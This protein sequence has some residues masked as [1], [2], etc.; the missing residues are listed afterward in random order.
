MPGRAA[1]TAELRAIARIGDAD[2]SD[3][4]INVLNVAQ[5]G[6]RDIPLGQVSAAAGRASI[7]FCAAAIDAAMAGRSRCG[8]GGAAERDLDRAGRHRVRRPSVVRGAADRHRRERGL[9]DAVL[10]RHPDRALHLH[11]SVREAIG[12]IT[13]D[14]VARVDPRD[15]RRAAPARRGA[16]QDRGQRAQSARRRRRAVRPRGDRDH[17]ACDRGRRGAGACGRRPVRRRHH[18]P[19]AGLSTPSWSCCTTRATSPR[20]CWRRTP[21]SALS[22]GTPILF[23]SVAHGTGHDIAG[24]GIADPAAMIEAVLRLAKA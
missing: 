15:R 9:H 4:R 2:C 12:A 10:R 22:I 20:S 11:R 19:H 5:P 17:Q 13:R 24:K 8:G 14:N 6:G 1:S 18:V 21:P 16:A 23:A 3:S 7:A